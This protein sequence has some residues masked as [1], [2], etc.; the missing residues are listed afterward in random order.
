MHKDEKI[1]FDLT[2]V[3]QQ[4]HGVLGS[5]GG[6]CVLCTCVIGERVV[7]DS[8]P[9]AVH[10]VEKFSAVNRIPGGYKKREGPSSD[11]EILVTRAIDRAVRATIPHDFANEINITIQALSWDGYSMEVLSIACASIALN[12]ANVTNKLVAAAR[13][14]GDFHNKAIKKMGDIAAKGSADMLQ[15]ICEDK[16]VMIEFMGNKANSSLFKSSLT[17]SIKFILEMQVKATSLANEIIELQKQA[18][19]KIKHKYQAKRVDILSK[20]DLQIEEK[21]KTYMAKYIQALSIE[22][23]KEQNIKTCEIKS[24]FLNHFQSLE[25]KIKAQHIF[26]NLLQ[27]AFYEK[28]IKEKT[29]LD[30]RKFDQVRPIS[31]KA[32]FLPAIHGSALFNRG[33][34]QALVL[35]TVG[36]SLDAQ[37]IE[38]LHGLHKEN[39][40]LHY[41]FP[42]YSVGKI[43][44]VG[45]SISR[46][47]IGHG[48]LARKAFLPILPEKLNCVIRI[49]SDITSSNGSSSMATVCAASLALFDAGV[50][51][52]YHVAGISIGLLE[53]DGKKKY[54]YLLTD[55]TACEDMLGKMDFKIAG[56][57]K[58]ITAL[59]L[60][61][62]NCGITTEI[63]N[64][65][66]KLGSKHIKTILEKMDEEIKVP[67]KTLHAF[68]EVIQ[69]PIS[70]ISSIIGKNGSTINQLQ[71][72][73]NV[74]LDVDKKGK[75]YITPNNSKLTLADIDNVIKQIN[76]LIK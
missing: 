9:L 13:I 56:T 73:Y 52:P 32:K 46:R 30:G 62:K 28:M 3:A 65:A 75:L 42:A 26:K 14:T 74:K 59:Q 55:I 54:S 4:A 69:V 25:D 36:Q 29:R 17:N 31:L 44:K 60:D 72:D 16:I 68:K 45:S 47:E 39:F 63:F 70:K 20:V 76:L 66:L 10:Y 49:V 2:S 33:D 53:N 50:E 40:L 38:S 22:G 34:T 15:A 5:I 24:E 41:N 1:Q 8:A 27:Q 64:K 23:Q 7:S 57:K 18:L 71:T 6:S 21:A 19:N 67:N 35:V 51:L 61:I 11:H 43:G 58:E 37:N 12:L 48:E